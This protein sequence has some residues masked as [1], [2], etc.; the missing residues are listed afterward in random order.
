MSKLKWLKFGLS[1][2]AL[3]AA[4]V[5]LPIA[6]TSCNDSGS[7]ENAEQDSN[8]VENGEQAINGEQAFREAVLSSG[9]VDLKDLSTPKDKCVYVSQDQPI[10]AIKNYFINKM[11]GAA[12]NKITVNPVTGSTS[13]TF[14]CTM[15]NKTLTYFA[16]L[17]NGSWDSI[18]GQSQNNDLKNIKQ[19]SFGFDIGNVTPSSNPDGT[20][21]DAYKIYPKFLQF[22]WDNAN[23]PSWLQNNSIRIPLSSGKYKNIVYVNKSTFCAD[24]TVSP[25]PTD[26]ELVFIKKLTNKTT[27]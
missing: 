5:T 19:L 27:F 21:L 20:K 14:Q 2:T 6:L 10:E 26:G 23:K 22:S 3:G 25:A 7:D 18:I 16:N 4:A 24:Q 12:T 1:M 17:F 15:S 9:L 8:G 13:N 11:S